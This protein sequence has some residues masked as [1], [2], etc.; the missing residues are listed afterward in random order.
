MKPIFVC[1]YPA[2]DLTS[3]EVRFTVDQ[4]KKEIEDY[5]FMMVPSSTEQDFRFELHSVADVDPEDFEK[6]KQKILGYIEEKRDTSEVFSREECVFAY[7]PN[8]EECLERCI[9]NLK[10]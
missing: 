4:V 1:F 10:Q 2:E 3:M 9:H 8:P 7:C 5:H 6:F